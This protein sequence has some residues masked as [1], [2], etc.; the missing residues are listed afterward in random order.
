MAICVATANG[1]K[2]AWIVVPNPLMTVSVVFG[3]PEPLADDP[4]GEP[5]AATAA[6]ART[7]LRR[8]LPPRGNGTFFLTVAS[9]DSNHERTEVA[10]NLPI[11][12]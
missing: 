5:Q 9:S 2:F 10:A 3:L 7:A 4:L 11:T 1:L 12:W 8:R 6:P